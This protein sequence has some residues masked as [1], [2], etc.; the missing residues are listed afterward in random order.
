METQRKL[1]ENKNKESQRGLRERIT[2]KAECWRGKR[3]IEKN[4]GHLR[5]QDDT[6]GGFFLQETRCPGD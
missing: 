5:M 3:E 4:G 1:V 6:A 2:D